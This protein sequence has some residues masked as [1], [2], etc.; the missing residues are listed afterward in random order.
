MTGRGVSEYDRAV[1][2]LVRDA[3]GGGDAGGGCGGGAE[4]YGRV[5]AADVGEGAGGG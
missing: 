4:L 5:L 3:G 2:G 1:L